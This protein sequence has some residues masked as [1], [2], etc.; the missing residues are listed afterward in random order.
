MDY[1]NYCENKEPI[2]LWFAKINDVIYYPIYNTNN[3]KKEYDFYKILDIQKIK[4]NYKHY[5]PYTH[6]FTLQN[7]KDNNIIIIQRCLKTNYYYTN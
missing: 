4:K 5:A 2:M 1:I 6:E 7:C 3:N